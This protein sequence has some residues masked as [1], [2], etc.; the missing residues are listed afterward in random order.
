MRSLPPAKTWI[1]LALVLGFFALLVTDVA[2]EKPSS[3]ERRTEPIRQN[4]AR[5]RKVLLTLERQFESIH[6]ASESRQILLMQDAVGFLKDYLLPHL[7]AEETVLYPAVDRELPPSRASVTQALKWE[8]HLMRLWIAELEAL[9]D[10]SMPDHNAFTRRG[11]R[12]LGLIEAHFDVEE[13]VLLP[14]L[15]QAVPPAIVR[16]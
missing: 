8:H 14:V 16:P 15:D 10:V 12:L 4:L 13:A 2:R 11:E 3:E 5:L 7:S 6:E 1:M 9:A